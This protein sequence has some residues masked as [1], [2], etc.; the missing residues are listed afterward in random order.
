MPVKYDSL[1]PEKAWHRDAPPPRYSEIDERTPLFV[2]TEEP[3]KHV[4]GLRRSSLLLILYMLFYLVYLVTGG[5]VFAVL[6]A[7]EEEDLKISVMASKKAFLTANPCVKG[8]SNIVEKNL[9]ELFFGCFSRL[10]LREVCCG[11]FIHV[12]CCSIA[13]K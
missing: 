11:H 12:C 1:L 9:Y 13:T 3:V 6:E 7:P 10:I 4:F 8:E 2:K 5:L